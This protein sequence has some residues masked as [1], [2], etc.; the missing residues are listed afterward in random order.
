M[1][2]PVVPTVAVVAA[3]TTATRSGVTPEPTIQVGGERRPVPDNP[4]AIGRG[5]SAVVIGETKTTSSTGDQ[6][7]KTEFVKVY[8]D[9]GVIGVAMLT[10]LVLCL[11]MGWFSIR[12]L[13]LYTSSLDSRDKAET[14]RLTFFDRLTNAV[15]VLSA[16]MVETKT[17]LRSD[18]D[19]QNKDAA[20]IKA[21]LKA[22]NDRVEK[23]I[24]TERV[25]EGSK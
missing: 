2:T 13:R 23:Y 5:Q 15:T 10:L 11:L 19:L 21:N 18:H 8:Q 14:L 17:I 6:Q 1:T 4:T 25:P 24:F 16:D 12:V 20:E 3:T 9:A 22:M 7:Y